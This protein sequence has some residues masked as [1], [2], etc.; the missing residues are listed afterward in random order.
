M[1][2]NKNPRGFTHDTKIDSNQ[3][4]VKVDFNLVKHPLE[5]VIKI[6]QELKKLMEKQN[7]NL[8]LSWYVMT[9]FLIVVFG[10]IYTVFFPFIDSLFLS[11]HPALQLKYAMISSEFVFNKK[12]NINGP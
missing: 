6:E 8:S 11:T 1:K 2:K 9:V 10:M 12:P 3:L 4:E 5:E 7:N